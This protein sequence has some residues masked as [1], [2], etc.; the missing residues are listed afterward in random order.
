MNEQQ[1]KRFIEN[2]FGEIGLAAYQEYSKSGRGVTILDLYGMPDA[3]GAECV[4]HYA[5]VI[6]DQD[7]RELVSRY[8]PETQFVAV[9]HFDN[10]S[11]RAVYASPDGT[12]FRDLL[13]KKSG[14]RKMWTAEQNDT[15]VYGIERRTGL[16]PRF[17]H[18]Q[19]RI[20]D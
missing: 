20:T 15:R 10:E 5:D 8:D 3:Q 6:N 11:V 19:R 7:L 1:G 12:T 16:V 2:H 17:S 9:A 4:V 14:L 13:K 18:P